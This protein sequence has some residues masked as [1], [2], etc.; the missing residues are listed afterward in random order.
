VGQQK[1]KL[2]MKN[3][4][5]KLKLIDENGKEIN[6]KLKLTQYYA[7]KKKGVDMFEQFLDASFKQLN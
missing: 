6:G 7:L 4:V 3:S 1:Q 2:Y 5:V